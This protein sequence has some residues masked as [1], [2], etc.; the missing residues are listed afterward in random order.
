MEKNE[1][2]IWLE[3]TF[4]KTQIELESLINE[5]NN[6]LEAKVGNIELHGPGW[7]FDRFISLQFKMCEMDSLTG[8]IS[9]KLPNNQQAISNFQKF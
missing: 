3:R 4:V 8:G 5:T 9:I 1:V 2:Y 7:V 6:E